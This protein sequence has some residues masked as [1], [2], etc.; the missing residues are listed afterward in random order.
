[1]YIIHPCRSLI[2]FKSLVTEPTDDG[3]VEI[4][5]G[6]AIVPRGYVTYPI[7][8]P[9]G[10]VSTAGIDCSGTLNDI[11]TPEVCSEANNNSM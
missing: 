7:S 3:I 2:C 5:G 4:C 9:S 10:S 11:V 6:S 1:M 8:L